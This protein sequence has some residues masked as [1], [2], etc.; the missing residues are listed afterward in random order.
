M[1]HIRHFK[2]TLTNFY[3]Q[4]GS[5]NTKSNLGKKEFISSYRFESV[6]RVTKAGA[7]GRIMGIGTNAETLLQTCLQLLGL[8]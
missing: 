4:A 3:S 2:N 1:F 6:M 7:Q 8:P 5:V